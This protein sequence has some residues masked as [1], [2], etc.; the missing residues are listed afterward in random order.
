MATGVLQKFC[1]LRGRGARQCRFEEGVRQSPSAFLFCLCS[2]AAPAPS[3]GLC[4]LTSKGCSVDQCS[5]KWG[6]EESNGPCFHAA[7]Q[8]SAAR[9]LFQSEACSSAGCSALHLLRQTMILLMILAPVDTGTDTAGLPPSPACRLQ[10]F[11]EQVL[12]SHS[13][14][15]ASA[16]QLLSSLSRPLVTSFVSKP[17]LLCERHTAEHDVPPQQVHCCEL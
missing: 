16:G 15:T 1:R 8:V 2:S 7:E 12:Q 5:T 10:N 13:V 6:C 14:V 17:N 11:T 4:C 3:S 9:L